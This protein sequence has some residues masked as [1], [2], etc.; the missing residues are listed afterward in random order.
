MRANRLGFAMLMGVMTVGIALAGEEGELKREAVTFHPRGDEA[1]NLA[2][3]IIWLP[4]DDLPPVRPGLVVCHPDPR[5]GGTMQNNV[6]CSVAERAAGAGLIVLR[7]NFRGA[8]G[9]S[10]SF[11]NGVGEVNDALGALDYLRQRSEVNAERVL[12][13]GYSFGSVVGLKAALA[14]KRVRGCACVGFP[15]PPE[16]K[17]LSPFSFIRGTKLPLLFVSGSE[18]AYSGPEN[19]RRLLKLTGVK[20]EV[21]VVEGSDHFFSPPGALAEM[22][23]LVVQCAR[24]LLQ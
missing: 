9:S 24:S 12:V 20:G 21:A 11:D 22:S 19:I 5:M 15:L 2:G 4:R 7:F 10:G 3:E 6:V 17:V 1:V 14:D 13:V 8:G 23:L 18:D 16:E